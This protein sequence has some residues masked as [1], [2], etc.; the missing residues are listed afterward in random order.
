MGDNLEADIGGARNVGM[1]TVWINRGWETGNPEGF[2]PDYEARSDN[3][4]KDLLLSLL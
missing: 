2:T 3:E 4:L 1:K